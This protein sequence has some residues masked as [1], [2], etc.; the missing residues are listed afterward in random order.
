[1]RKMVAE[2]T[3]PWLDLSRTPLWSKWMISPRRA[4]SVV[5][6]E[7]LSESI[8]ACIFGLTRARRRE[9]KPWDS[10]AATCV[11][12]GCGLAIHASYQLFGVPT[13][14]QQVRY[15]PLQQGGSR[16]IARVITPTG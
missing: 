8:Y 12:G 11:I 9:S 13:H 4:R 1:M 2:S 5:M 16:A 3:G 10:G 15:W 6:P 14:K 7:K